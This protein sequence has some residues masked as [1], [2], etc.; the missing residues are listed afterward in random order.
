M[1]LWGVVRGWIHLPPLPTRFVLAPLPLTISPFTFS[2]I[3]RIYCQGFRLI[4]A[5]VAEPLPHRWWRPPP[6]LP[7]QPRRFISSWPLFPPFRWRLFVPATQDLLMLSCRVRCYPRSFSF[8]AP[9]RE[10]SLTRIINEIEGRKM[11]RKSLKRIITFSSHPP[12][13]KGK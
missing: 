11:G 2:A 4:L 6:P 7:S 9:H 1:T 13:T 8:F 10:T 3:C 12:T 5:P